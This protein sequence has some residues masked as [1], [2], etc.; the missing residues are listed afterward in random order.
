MKDCLI[1]LTSSSQLVAICFARR[2][3]PKIVLG[4]QL[5][6]MADFQWTCSFP[7]FCRLL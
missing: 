2:R 7:G 5:F 4:F 1:A 3:A 6:R